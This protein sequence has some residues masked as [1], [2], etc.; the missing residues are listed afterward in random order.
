MSEIVDTRINT[1]GIESP[2]DDFVPPEEPVFIL[3][4]SQLRG[5]IKP[6]LDRIT[7]LEKDQSTLSENQLIQ[8]RLIND[9]REAIKKD[10]QPMQKDRGEILRALIM[11]N[12]G[13]M[14]RSE[15]RKRMHLSEQAF[16]NLLA[17]VNDIESLPCRTNKRQR[18]LILR[19]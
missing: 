4:T 19:R 5:I 10:P 9:L 6:L 11:V 3:T 17:T 16:T 13:K 18:L 8:L 14:L 7:I 12:G 1:F 15:V 2:K